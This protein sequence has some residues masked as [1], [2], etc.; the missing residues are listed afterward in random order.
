MSKVADL[1]DERTLIADLLEDMA[2]VGERQVL[3]VGLE[4]AADWG[5]RN[6]ARVVRGQHPEEES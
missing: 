1:G 5:L 4:E 2:D 3:T 6:A